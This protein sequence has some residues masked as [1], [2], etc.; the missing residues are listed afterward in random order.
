MVDLDFPAKLGVS[1]TSPVDKNLAI[2]IEA[3]LNELCAILKVSLDVLSWRVQQSHTFVSEVLLF[4]EAYMRVSRLYF[5]GSGKNVSNPVTLEL[6]FGQC[7]ANRAQKQA[8]SD[9]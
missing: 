7:C 1:N 2:G 9:L 5:V 6:F 8:R 4:K 3:I